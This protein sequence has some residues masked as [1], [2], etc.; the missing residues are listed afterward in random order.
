[1]ARAYIQLD[2]D[3]HGSFQ[4]AEKCRPLLRGE[5]TVFLRKEKREAR[6]TRKKSSGSFHLSTP[7]KQLWE[8]L[9]TRRKALAEKEGVP[10][11]VIFHDATLME[12]I[13][14]QPRTL[15][16]LSQINGIGSARLEKY[17]EDFLALLIS[18][19]D[20]PENFNE[21]EKPDQL[22]PTEHE[23]FALFQSGM[24]MESICQQRSI[25]EG[26]LYRHLIAAIELG[27]IP[28]KDVIE[29]SD[30]EITKIQDILETQREPNGLIKL[31]AAY[32]DLDMAYSYEQLRCIK[33]EM[34]S[35]AHNKC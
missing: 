13:E 17:G 18:H 27:L 24:P 2:A 26:T 7:N 8:Q 25:S 29:I 4:L 31:K 35:A 32:E 22:S 14:Q 23:S 1:M 10:P 6:T 21:K 12:M 11:Y 20:S 15:A 19:Q 16:G 3:G 30:E 33:A 28:A 34:S 9:R 5:S